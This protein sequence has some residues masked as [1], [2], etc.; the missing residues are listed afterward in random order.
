MKE[1]I[2]IQSHSDDLS[3]I[4]NFST[5]YVN[6]PSQ[7]YNLVDEERPSDEKPANKSDNK[8]IS[9][10]N[11]CP[12]IISISKEKS[13][14]SNNAEKI[15][16]INLNNF[17]SILTQEKPKEK[18]VSEKIGFKNFEV[19]KILGA[20]SFG[21]VYLV[22]KKDNNLSF[23]MKALKKRDLIIKKQLRYAVTEVNVLKRCNH[24]FVLTLHYAFQVIFVLIKLF[25]ENT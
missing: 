21:K 23:A 14:P 5:N 2:V 24:P 10:K 16:P 4:A 22:K 13:Y 11:T 12:E 3:A 15:I 6:K 9:P 7:I 19:L 20:G 1:L 8:D 18:S 25:K 17:S